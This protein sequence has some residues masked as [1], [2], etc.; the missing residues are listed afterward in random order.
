MKMTALFLTLLTSATTL[1]ASDPMVV[2]RAL[3]NKGKEPRGKDGECS[4]EDRKKVRQ[5]IIDAVIEID[6]RHLRHQNQRQLS[7]P[8]CCILCEGFHEVSDH[9]K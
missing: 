1:V 4:S 8:I 9:E 2:L 6:R 5:A 7:H 3:A